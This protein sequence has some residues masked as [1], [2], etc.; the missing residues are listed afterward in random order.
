MS[1]PATPQTASPWKY[2]E[3]N[4][5]SKYKQLFIKG[6]RI[7]ARV[8]FGLYASDE[9]PRTPEQIATDYALPVEAVRE[10]IAYCQSNPP[11]IEEDFRREEALMD[12]TGMNDPNYKSTGKPKVLNAQDIAALRKGRGRKTLLPDSL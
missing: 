4:P 8:L 5:K 12:A 1:A 7:R 11:E 2:L 3:S 6:T 10:A 9:E